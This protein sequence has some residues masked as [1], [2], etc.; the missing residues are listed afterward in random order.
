[1]ASRAAVGSPLLPQ[2]KTRK[3]SLS[4]W[5]P[6]PGAVSQEH[7]QVALQGVLV[8]GTAQPG[9]ASAHIRSD[10]VQGV[11]ALQF[12]LV[13]DLL[14]VEPEHRLWGE[15]AEAH[16]GLHAVIFRATVHRQLYGV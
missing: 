1:M 5:V 7:V 15:R 2:W 16:H 4:C 12:V 13:E 14:H 8:E 6:E 11:E 10:V 3:K 9:P